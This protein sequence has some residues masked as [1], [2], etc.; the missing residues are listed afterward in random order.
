M[1]RERPATRMKRISPASPRCSTPVA[2]SVSSNTSLR[3]LSGRSG[4]SQPS[5][6]LKW[7][8]PFICGRAVVRL[9]SFSP[10]S[11]Q[12]C[13][14]PLCRSGS[15]ASVG[16]CSGWLR[17][18]CSHSADY[19][20]A[21]P[22]FVVLV[23]SPVSSPVRCSP[24]TTC[25]RL[26]SPALKLPTPAATGRSP[27]HSRSPQ[28]FIGPTP[29]STRAVGRKSPGMNWRNWHSNSPV[30]SASSRPLQPSGWYCPPP[31]SS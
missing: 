14:S 23:C 1:Y 8:S 31:G 7:P 28:S 15:M 21:S 9:L 13:S 25:S 17:R 26:R 12:S 2:Y 4:R 20:S 24:S 27:W 29:R 10:P 18:K 16:R 11:P 22:S 30:V 6:P 3:I 19:A 5:A